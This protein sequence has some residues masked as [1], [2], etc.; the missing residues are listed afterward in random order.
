[1]E[2]I[3][4]NTKNSKTNEPHKLVLPLSQKL[5]IRSSSKHVTLQN[6]PICYTC[7]SIRQQCK[8]IKIRV[9]VPILNDDF[10]LPDG[11]YTVSHFKDYTE[12]IINKQETLSINSPIYIYFKRI[13]NRLVF[14]HKE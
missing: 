7:K 12:Y 9:I 14:I 5:N 6:L 13:N 8:S 10:E 11:S 4:M 1:M 3:F 2:A